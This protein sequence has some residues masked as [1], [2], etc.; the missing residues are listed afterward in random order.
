MQWNCWSLRCSWNITCRRCPNYIFILYLTPGLN[1]MG[2]D[3]CK[4]RRESLKFWDLVHFILEG[5]QY[6]SFQV[7]GLPLFH[8]TFYW[9]NEVIQNGWRDPKNLLG[10]WVLHQHLYKDGIISVVVVPSKKSLSLWC[11]MKPAWLRVKTKCE[12]NTS[13]GLLCCQCYLHFRSLLS[14]SCEISSSEL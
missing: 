12:K 8:M 2:K 14:K 9:Q 7:S 1:G 6:I 3:N 4:T 11:L 5:W 10:T 13:S